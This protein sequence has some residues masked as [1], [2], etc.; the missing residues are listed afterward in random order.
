LAL[1]ARS[2]GRGEHRRATTTCA[3]AFRNPA[4]APMAGRAPATFRA[5]LETS[6]G[7]FVIEV[8]REWAPLGADRFYNL[9]T[10]GYYDGT[11]V[12]RVIPGFMA[13][14]GIHGDPQVAAVWRAARIPDDPVREHNTRGMMS[15]AT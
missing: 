8:H 9:V 1:H 5:R 15:F 3:P 6:K 4:G 14:F 12:F 7:A 11:R 10:S 2:W 13:Q